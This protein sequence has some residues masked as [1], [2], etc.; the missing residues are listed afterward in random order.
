LDNIF[1]ERLWRNV[2][3]EDVY[4]NG[5]ATMGELHAGLTRYFA[6]YNEERPHQGLE[7]RT[8]NVAYESGKGVG[9][10][11]VDR[12]GSVPDPSSPKPVPALNVGSAGEHGTPP[13]TPPCREQSAMTATLAAG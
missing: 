13:Q 10:M 9:A 7:Y 8:P 6:F 12:Y 1:V 4:L 2:K 5:Y 3:Y 11:I